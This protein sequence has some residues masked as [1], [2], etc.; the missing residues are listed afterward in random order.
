MSSNSYDT[1]ISHCVNCGEEIDK[2][3]STAEANRAP[4]EGDVAVCLYCYHVM[5]YDINQQLRNPTDEEIKELAGSPD[6]IHTMD[7]LSIF[8][9]MRKE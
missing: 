8:K 6:L 9:L 7:V 3:G 4:Q 2:A 1:R 5:V